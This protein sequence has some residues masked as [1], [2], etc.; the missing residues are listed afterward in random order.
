MSSQQPR[1][2]IANIEEY[3]KIQ[4]QNAEILLQLFE[5]QNA[6]I[7]EVFNSQIAM[8]TKVIGIQNAAMARALG[9]TPPPSATEQGDFGAS[10]STG[11]P[12]E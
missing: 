6:V 4:L 7:T 11:A 10:S 3:R 8:V 1:K 5:K 2:K 12:P 9:L